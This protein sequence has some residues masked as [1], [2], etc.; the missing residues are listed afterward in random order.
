MLLQMAAQFNPTRLLSR[1][2][3]A[4]CTSVGDRSL[5]LR[6]SRATQAGAILA[7]LLGQIDKL[8]TVHCGVR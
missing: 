2:L 3:E 5:N 7:A 1:T 4:P 8:E 6:D